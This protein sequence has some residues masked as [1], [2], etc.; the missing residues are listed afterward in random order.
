MTKLE[1]EEQV[2]I[3]LEYRR[4]AQPGA[5]PMESRIA[6]R[7]QADAIFEALP[8]RWIYRVRSEIVDLLGAL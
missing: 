7:K 1:I 3:G 8:K 6:A 4:K 2:L 5:G